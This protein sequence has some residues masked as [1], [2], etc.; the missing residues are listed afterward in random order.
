MTTRRLRL[1]LNAQAMGEVILDDREIGNLTQ[2]VE[3]LV[4]M[5]AGKPVLAVLAFPLV[6][7][8]ADLEADVR[9]VVR[10]PNDTDR[11]GTGATLPEALRDLA[12]LVEHD[13]A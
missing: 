9:Y 4:N 2:E 13:E 8:A 7:V 6:S 3:L 1:N 5:V 11:E 12:E 10:L